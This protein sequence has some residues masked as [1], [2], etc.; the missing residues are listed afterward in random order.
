MCQQPSPGN[1]PAQAIYS[2]VPPYSPHDSERIDGTETFSPA[3]SAVAATPIAGLDTTK[4]ADPGGEPYPL[5]SDEEV[6][7]SQGNRIDLSGSKFNAETLVADFIAVAI[8]LGL[9]GFTAATIAR[10]GKAMTEGQIDKWRN[11]ASVVS[12]NWI[13]HF[14]LTV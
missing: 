8:P 7:R 5:S 3:D 1:E 10:N 6:Y 4:Q 9:V 2:T 13:E 11:V 12:L 14:P